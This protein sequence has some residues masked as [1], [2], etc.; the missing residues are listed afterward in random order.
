MVGDDLLD[1]VTC[2]GMGKVPRSGKM[3]GSCYHLRLQVLTGLLCAIKS[4]S[5][6]LGFLPPKSSFIDTQT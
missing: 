1:D 3:T 2:M 5:L 6:S 4:P